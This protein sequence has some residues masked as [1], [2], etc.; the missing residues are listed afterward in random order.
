[1]PRKNNLSENNS[2]C[3]NSARHPSIEQ[4]YQHRHQQ[5]LC[6]YSIFLDTTHQA[7]CILVLSIISVLVGDPT[8]IWNEL[9]IF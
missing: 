2:V 8:D 3:Q 9:H 5:S 6:Y 1:M 7:V 4:R